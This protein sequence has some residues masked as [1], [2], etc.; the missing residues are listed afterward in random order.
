MI[1]NP[2]RSNERFLKMQE[3]QEDELDPYYAGQKLMQ[4][5]HDEMIKMPED[6]R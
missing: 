4:L 6:Y 5:A 2:E 1:Q 3:W